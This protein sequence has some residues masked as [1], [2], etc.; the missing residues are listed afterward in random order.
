[1]SAHP[2]RRG[3]H[4]RSRSQKARRR[5]SN[6]RHYYNRSARGV[7]PG[8]F[9][10]RIQLLRPEFHNSKKKRLG[11]D[12]A[13]TSLS[14][15]DESAV[16]TGGLNLQRPRPS[17]AHSVPVARGHAIRLAVKMRHHWRR[18]WDMR[19]NAEPSPDL[20]TG[21][22]SVT[23]ADDLEALQRG[24]ENWDF[25]KNDQRKKG[26]KAHDVALHVCRKCRV[27]PGHIAEGTEFL[28]KIKFTGSGLEAIKKAYAQES[29][30]TDRKYVIKMVQGKLNV[31]ELKR[32]RVAY[33][34]KGVATQ[35]TLEGDPKK[36]RPRTVVKAHGRVN[37]KKETV[38]VHRKEALRR[39]G[40]S[41]LEKDF[42]KLDSVSD[43][44]R[45]ASGALRD[46][47][48]VRRRAD[49][50]IPGIPFI[51]RG[52]TVRWINHEPGWH[53][54]SRTSTDLQYAFVKMCNHTLDSS[55]FWTT[56]TLTQADPYLIDQ[57]RRDH[58]SRDKKRRQRR[59]G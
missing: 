29:D 32:G 15:D 47:L 39:F 50:T 7:T 37:G 58:D 23:I 13:T 57:R 21:N 46:E 16:M 48:R 56:M 42:G 17:K 25:E 14:W 26:W 8:E 36:D 22:V 52:A 54:K 40:R 34:I 10:F 51:E 20:L 19:V 5:G 1:M 45:K 27:R 28:D 49:I 6:L 4:Q 43:L 31:R 59:R 2:D 44:R 12:R 24:E 33:V 18:I 41:V 35:T 11:L 38:T 55:G 30:K 3:R 53:G 9:D